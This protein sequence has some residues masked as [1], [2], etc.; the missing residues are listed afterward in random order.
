MQG[1]YRDP[2]ATAAVLSPD[3]WLRTGDL[4]FVDAEGY[5][6]VSGR[7]KDLIFLG[8]EN[9]VPTDVEEIVDHLQG[10]RYSAAVGLESERT[11][12]QRLYVVAEVR[13][14]SV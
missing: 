4:G 12:S 8:G 6:Y 14:D 9:I 11:G 13:E 1:Y 3:G 5:L 2:E 7:L 10:V